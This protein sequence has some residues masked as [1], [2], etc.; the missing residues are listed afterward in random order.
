MSREKFVV[1]TER[2]GI[3]NVFVN[4]Y[5]SVWYEKIM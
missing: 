2:K 3:L 5:N 1:T 4:S